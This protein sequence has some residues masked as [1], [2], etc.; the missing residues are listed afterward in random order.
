MTMTIRFDYPEAYHYLMTHKEVYTLRSYRKKDGVHHLLTNQALVKINRFVKVAF[1][2]FIRSKKE[3]E[4]YVRKSGYDTVEDWVKAAK[5]APFLHY[6]YLLRED[7]KWED[8][9]DAENMHG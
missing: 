4:V 8:A 9:E 3:L 2:K 1:E 6:V 7:Y 5:G